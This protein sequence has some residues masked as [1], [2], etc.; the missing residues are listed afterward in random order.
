V[1]DGLVFVSAWNNG[2]RIYDVGN[3]LLG[4][5][6][7]QPRFVD[8]IVTSS[9]GLPGGAAVHNAW[10]FWSPTGQKR[11]VFVGQE[12]PGQVGLRSTG[13]IHV[14]D[15]TDL[16]NPVEV[17]FYHMADVNG[18]TAGT[19]NFWVDE[20]NQVLFAAYYNG[21]VVAL[22][23]SGNLSGDL[24]QNEIAR[25]R[26]GGSSTY[27]WGVQ[28]HQGAVYA[29]DMVNGLYRLSFTGSAFGAAGGGNVPE[30]FT[31]DLW[32]H[33]GHAYTGTWGNR[34][35]V[36]GNAVKIWAVG[37][38]APVLVDSIITPDILTVSDLEVSDDGRIL[39]FSAEGGPAAGIY[40]YDVSTPTDPVFLGTYSVPAGVHTTTFAT[41]AGRR[42]VFAAKDP[43]EGGPALLILDVTGLWP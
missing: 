15:V 38:G 29:T 39:M 14:V 9:N 36:P 26:P 5:S 10:W 27:V 23:I 21:G 4:G 1:R 17:A 20:A 16:F 32:V 28:L 6:P 30:R 13:D 37:A 34:S 3:G 24:A 41:I 12:G 22:D 11:Y 19:H 31:S 33:G 42:Y 43:P 2:L 8:S 7:A 25:I 18:Q 40:F 35:G